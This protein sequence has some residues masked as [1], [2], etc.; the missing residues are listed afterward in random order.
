MTREEQ[1]FLKHDKLA[2][3]A[4]RALVSEG[5]RIAC[6]TYV[7]RR[8]LPVLQIAIRKAGEAMLLTWSRKNRQ[9][10]EMNHG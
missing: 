10:M 5:A 9:F 2:R 8:G 7:C 1:N 4:M 3:R 6:E